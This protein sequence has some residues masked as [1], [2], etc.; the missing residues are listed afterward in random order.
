[1]AGNETSR[2]QYPVNGYALPDDWQRWTDRPQEKAKINVVHETKIDQV[3][4]FALSPSTS[5]LAV[6]TGT[7][8]V[9]LLDPLTGKEIERLS[10]EKVKKCREVGFSPDGSLIFRLFVNFSG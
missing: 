2:S 7:K 4:S 9:F 1:M 5:T 6:A 8:D 10:C 3:W